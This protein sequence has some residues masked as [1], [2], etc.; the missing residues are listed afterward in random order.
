[1]RQPHP[2]TE[3][4]VGRQRGVEPDRGREGGDRVDTEEARTVEVSGLLGAGHVGHDKVARRVR[5]TV[6]VRGRPRGPRA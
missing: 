2:D 1:M 3:V 4:V 6:Q 5:D